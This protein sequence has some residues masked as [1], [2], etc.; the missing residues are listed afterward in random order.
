[1]QVHATTET[2]VSAEIERA[3]SEWPALTYGLLGAAALLAAVLWMIPAP[4]GPGHPLPEDSLSEAR[5]VAA[6][7]QLRGELEAYRWAKGA[8]PQSL[9]ALKGR[10]GWGL[11]LIPLDQYSYSRSGRGYRLRRLI[12]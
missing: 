5:A 3:V 2:A 9:T 7:Q 4:Q 6:T 8:Y 1:M 11:A 12:P 10:D